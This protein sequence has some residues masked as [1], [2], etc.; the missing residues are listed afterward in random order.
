MPTNKSLV[1][2]KKDLRVTDHEPLLRATSHGQCIGLFIIEADWL[3]SDEFSSKQLQ[4]LQDCLEELKNNLTK[5]NIPLLIMHGD[6]ITCFKGIHK[7]FAF[8]SI[9]SHMETGV[10]WTYQR[11]IKVKTWCRNNSIDWHESKQFAVIRKLKNRDAWNRS[12]KFIIERPLHEPVTL[13]SHQPDTT[14]INCITINAI[15]Q[16]VKDRLKNE[17]QRGGS[18]KANNIL[19]SFLT[20]RGMYYS[21]NMS[22]PNTAFEQCS[23]LSPHISWGT[24]S[25]SQIHIQLKI[26]QDKS[27]NNHWYRSLRA[28]EN[29]LWWHCHFIQKLES[30]PEIEFTNVNT[31]FNGMREENF[32]QE[33]FHAWCKGETG[34]PII[35]ACMRALHQHGWINFRMRAMLISFA[36]YQL[37]LHWQKPA[38]HL[39]KLFT[40]FEP[41][42]HYSQVQ[43]Q[44]GVTGI[45]AI[46]IYSAIK[47]AKD[48]D[49]DGTFIRKYCPELSALSNEN[50]H[51]P[52]LTPP[53][54]QMACGVVIGK[55]YPHP[56]VDHLE[57]YRHAKSNIFKW[58]SKPSTKELSKQILIKHASRKNSHFP[59]Q[60]RAI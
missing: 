32:N 28:F 23:R 16:L 11:D 56:I 9:Y 1:W 58:K 52:Q 42:I 45:N 30:E 15:D 59:T 49:P 20:Q 26:A 24:I 37:W 17:I 12:R 50:I 35:D 46:R 40:D 31:G 41:G 44:S 36:S 5:L 14:N 39:A 21:K 51:E 19:S 38:H 34:F 48:Q 18:L 4:F 54:E 25:M 2:F 53:L 27:N 47:Q 33:Y 6:C 10:N 60:K 13:Q 3:T 22:S 7:K 55:D 29:R 43:M 8:D 57:A